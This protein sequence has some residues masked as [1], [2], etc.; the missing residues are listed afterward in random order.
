MS[1]RLTVL[2]RSPDKPKPA[3]ARYIPVLWAR[4]AHYALPTIPILY[5]VLFSTVALP[6]AAQSTPVEETDVKQ[7]IQSDAVLAARQWGLTDKEWREYM[8][9]MQGKRGIWSPGLDPLTALGVHAESEDQR[10]H[11]AELYVRQAFERTQDELAFQRAVN[12][13]WARLYP[14]QALLQNTVQ[15]RFPY[16][17]PTRYALVLAADCPAC[18]AALQANLRQASEGGPGLDIYL[19]GSHSDD[20]LLRTWAATHNIAA[21]AV[22]SGR[23]T[24]NHGTSFADID[25]LPV[26]YARQG[27]GEWVQQ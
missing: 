1:P 26:V 2:R 20:H 21:E 7:S 5:L 4:A 8:D 11:L 23:I 9:I 24:L 6:L 3:F 22:S 25:G 16:D 10:R 15:R 18:D 13:A 17:K 12:D 14:R 27:N 19:V